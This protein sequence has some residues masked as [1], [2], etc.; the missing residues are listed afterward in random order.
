VSSFDFRGGVVQRNQME[1]MDPQLW[2]SGAD[3]YPKGSRM[4]VIQIANG[5]SQQD[6]L[7]GS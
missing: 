7:V 3:V 4:K 6:I 2:I 1:V 5:R